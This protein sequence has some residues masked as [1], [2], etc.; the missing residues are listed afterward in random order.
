MPSS[1][2]SADRVRLNRKGPARLRSRTGKTPARIRSI[3]IDFSD[4]IDAYTFLDPSRFVKNY[5]AETITTPSLD[6]IVG[7]VRRR[8]LLENTSS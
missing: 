8:L 5:Y 7:L 3:K 2:I 1:R 4:E 6:T